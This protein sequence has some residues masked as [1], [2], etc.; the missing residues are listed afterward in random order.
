MLNAITATRQEIA[1]L[2]QEKNFYLSGQQQQQQQPGEYRYQTT[3]AE[4]AVLLLRGTREF[5]NRVAKEIRHKVVSILNTELDEA[6]AE[7]CCSGCFIDKDGKV[8]TTKHALWKNKTQK[9]GSLKEVSTKTIG[10]EYEVR[11]IHEQD[12]IISWRYI[13]CPDDDFGDTDIATLVPVPHAGHETFQDPFDFFEKVEIPY[14]WDDVFVAGRRSSNEC[15]LFVDEGSY[16]RVDLDFGVVTAFADKGWSGGPVFHL[17]YGEPTLVG[18]IQGQWGHD[19]V[20]AKALHVPSTLLTIHN[21]NNEKPYGK[22]QLR[23]WPSAQKTT[24]AS[25]DNSDHSSEGN[26]KEKQNEDG[27]EK[28]KTKK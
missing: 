17:Y 11:F 24:P 8:L 23:P 7:A 1:A 9:N 4:A 10:G 20:A 16:N 12:K 22:L 14:Q 21:H 18:I 6:G 3:A 19:N 25:L 13:V 28:T 5:H 26:D 27:G 15:A 2:R